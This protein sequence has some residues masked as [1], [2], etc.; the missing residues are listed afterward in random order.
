MA[1]VKWRLSKPPEGHKASIIAVLYISDSVRPEIVTGE[2]VLPS[3]WT[4]SRVRNAPDRG[5]I[6]LH[7]STIETDLM[8]LWRDNKDKDKATLTHLARQI[9][10]G[11]SSGPQK[12]TFFDALDKLL[13]IYEK[14]K[15]EKTL[16]KF[17]TLRSYLQKFDDQK[18]PVTFEGMTF[19]FY[20]NFKEFLYSQPNQTFPDS[21]F[22]KK[23]DYW[24]IS[25]DKSPDPVGLFDDTVFK[26]IINLKIFLSWAQSREYPVHA[27]YP[28][29]KIIQRE[30]EPIAL[31]M[32]E[33]EKLEQKELTETHIDIGRDYLA[34]EC[35]TGQRISDLKR[36]NV[37]DYTDH[38]WSF[39][40]YKG[41][42]T[43]RKE[44]T[45]NVYFTGY[46]KPALFILAKHKFEMP[47]I[48]EQKLNKN[49][50][51]ACKLAGI[52][53][54]M[55]TERWVGNK[56]VRFYGKKYE[57]I[58]TH[59]GR[60]TF[61]TLGLQFMEPEMVMNLAGLKSYQT[62]KKYKAKS[63]PKVL[64]RALDKMEDDMA[65]MRKAN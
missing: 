11:S 16:K 59:T 35:R 25:K 42:G 46:C 21:Y 54:E 15:D 6:N 29:W 48:S 51:T 39:T 53:E 49:I 8:Q 40:Q 17:K 19:E 14:E 1:Q 30:Y 24:I 31:T 33:L 37:A 5:Q 4:G 57:F 61:I 55:Y 12:K 62:L 64:M 10:K 50:R 41:R 26:H 13:R 23:G 38:V 45:M 65:L 18:Y 52:D 36:F 7:L 47:A 22:H 43:R 63:E 58:S 34:L 3:N 56:C 2:K 44:E 60:K 28:K 27:S 32:A 9:V 20:D